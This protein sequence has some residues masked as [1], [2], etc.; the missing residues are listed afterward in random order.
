MSRVSS[1]YLCSLLSLQGVSS[2]FTWAFLLSVVLASQEAEEE[3]EEEEEATMI[4]YI[5]KF[6]H[7]IKQLV[8][9]LGRS[10]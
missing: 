4:N 7:E 6:V 9:H 2:L 3:G 10:A 5:A 8:R 1:L